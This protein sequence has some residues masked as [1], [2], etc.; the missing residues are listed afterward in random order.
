MKRDLV[1]NSQNLDLNT[2]AR[3]GENTVEK[4][5]PYLLNSTYATIIT[6]L[7]RPIGAFDAEHELEV[8][9]AQLK[10]SMESDQD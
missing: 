10:A 4:A 1:D 5:S 7:A 9:R 8:Y 3:K 2:T 6:N